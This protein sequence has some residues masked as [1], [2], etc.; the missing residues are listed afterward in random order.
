M[1][2]RLRD[3]IFEDLKVV[4]AKTGNWSAFAI[5]HGRVQDNFIDVD[6]QLVTTLRG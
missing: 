5:A 2:D 6:T 1:L 4:F 3:S